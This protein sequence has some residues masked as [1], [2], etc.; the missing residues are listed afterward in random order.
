MSEHQ[1]QYFHPGPPPAPQPGVVPLRPLGFGDVLTGVMN[2]VRRYFA[3]LYV[4]VLAATAGVLLVLA[5]YAVVAYGLLIDLYRQ[6][7]A[8][9]WYEPTDGQLVTLVTVAVSGWLLL[10]LCLGA[11]SVVAAATG[12]VVTRHAVI[13]KPVSTRAVWAESRRH[14]GRITAEYLLLGGGALLGTAVLMVLWVA[15]SAVLGSAVVGVLFG[16]LAVACWVGLFYAQVRLTLLVPVLVMEESRPLAAFPRAWRLNEGAWL[17]SFGIPYVVNLIASMGGQLVA[18]PFVLVGVLI[19]LPFG[20]DPQPPSP[21]V[22]VA[23]VLL[24][25]VGVLLS[26]AV[27]LP[28]LPVCHALLYVDRRIRRERLDIA[29]GEAAGLWTTQQPPAQPAEQPAEP[30]AEGGGVDPAE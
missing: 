22:L 4:P 14:L 19:A 12:T 9:K 18:T 15:V 25:L 29:L 16:L 21:G 1:Y 23:A 8:D 27:T 13:G 26:T 28:L 7:V 10:V 5:V 24:F 11:L 30:A 2:T 6:V 3:Q 17:R 20:A